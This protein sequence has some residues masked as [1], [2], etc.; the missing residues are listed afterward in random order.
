MLNTRRAERNH[1]TTLRLDSL[2]VLNE[3]S[4]GDDDYLGVA[5]SAP[6]YVTMRVESRFEGADS[7]LHLLFDRFSED[8]VFVE[9]GI[10]Q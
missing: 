10:Q 9:S 2:D 4:S 3:V 1:L 5:V 6:G 8:G 7:R